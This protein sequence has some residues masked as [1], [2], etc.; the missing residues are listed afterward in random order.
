MCYSTL[1]LPIIFLAALVGAGSASAEPILPVVPNWWEMADGLFASGRAEPGPMAE[2]TESRRSFGISTFSTNPY[3]LQGSHGE[4]SLKTSGNRGD[5][6]WPLV[7]G[8]QVIATHFSLEDSRFAGS[9]ARGDSRFDLRGEEGAQSLRIAHNY[10][11][12]RLRWG[13]DLRWVH[14]GAVI[15]FEPSY[16]IGWGAEGGTRFRVLATRRESRAQWHWKV[17][18]D[19]IGGDIGSVT[20][21]VLFELSFGD[22]FGKRITAGFSDDQIQRIDRQRVGTLDVGIAG[23]RRAISVMVEHPVDG[24]L[25]WRLRFR[26]GET[27]GDAGVQNITETRNL[28]RTET[29]FG[30]EITGS[31][32]GR[33]RWWTDFG[34]DNSS[35][36]AD[37]AVLDN[38]PPAFARPIAGGRLFSADGRIEG[39]RL[40]GRIRADRPIGKFDVE[41]GLCDYKLHLS[42]LDR[43][44]ANNPI[45]KTEFPLSGFTG[46]WLGLKGDIPLWRIDMQLNASQAF[47]LSQ[48]GSDPDMFGPN[49]R[50]SGGW[51]VSTGIRYNF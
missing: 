26:R 30:G 41:C 20:D 27:S 36:S 25:G 4:I 34:Y 7:I 21:G 5:L 16:E 22:L 49:A 23:Q 18:S 3:H 8:R 35:G 1:C 47:L 32:K 15:A 50:L 46:G 42:I 39:A 11:V 6:I 44:D 40:V 19:S 2:L 45:R 10:E 14:R 33:L 31:M 17:E 13:V 24:T 29:S 43:L 51:M 12:L 28:F 48:H 9:V 37:G 38:L